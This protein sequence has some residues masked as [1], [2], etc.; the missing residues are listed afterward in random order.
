MLSH[1]ITLVYSSDRK[2][3]TINNLLGLANYIF[4]TFLQAQLHQKIIDLPV[5]N[6]V[7]L[8]S[9]GKSKLVKANVIIFLQYLLSLNIVL[10]Q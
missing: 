6:I 9:L 5:Y 2:N 4:T 10:T 8:G 7:S 1:A 3:L